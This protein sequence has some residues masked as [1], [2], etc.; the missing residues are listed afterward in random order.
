M[1]P[2]A[3]A[4]TDVFLRK[5]RQGLASL[6]TAEQVDIIAELRSH[7]LERQREG[8]AD[9][10]AGFESPEVLAA[11][12]VAEHALRGGLARGTS[13]ALG[14]ALFVAARDSVAGLLWLLPLLTLQ[15]V[16]C[17]LLL[18]AALKPFLP[19][20]VGVWIGEGRFYAG[21]VS[22][23]PTMH[24]VLGWW[25]IPAFAGAGVLLFWLSTKAM[26]TLVWRRLEARSG[27]HV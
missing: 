23:H 22:N 1:K 3:P 13:W 9:P 15:L 25:A 10:L 21:I 18:A 11:D 17:G 2:S 8:R 20:L 5:V 12:L 6:P 19:D 24:E 27:L 4:S 16:A 14:K 7:L 26:T